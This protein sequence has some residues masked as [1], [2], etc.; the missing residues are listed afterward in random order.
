MLTGVGEDRSFDDGTIRRVGRPG[1]VPVS[2]AQRRMLFI[3][4][5]QPGHPVYNLPMMQQITGP[6]DR[7]VLES[8]F[9][10]VIARH[11]ALRTNFVLVA[12][13]WSQVVAPPAPAALSYRDLRGVASSDVEAAIASEG[14]RP[15]ELGTGL[16][17]RA[18]LLRT[19]DEDHLFLLTV[20]HLVADG[21]SMVRFAEELGASYTA[22][23]TGSVPVLPELAV[24]YGDVALWERERLASGALDE[25]LAY[26]RG[27]L[28]GGVPV[29]EM[30]TD[31]PRP[32]TFSYA[33]ESAPVGFDADLSERVR[34]RARD[35]GVTP[36]M[37]LLA[38]YTATLARWS[39]AE[40]VM[41]GTASAN[42]RLETANV[43]GLFVSTLPM[44][45]AVDGARSFAELLE[46]VK[47]ET[48]AT[49]AD[50]EVS[51]DQ[52]VRAVN[53]RARSEPVDRCSRRCSSC[54]NDG[55]TEDR[56]PCAAVPS[57]ESVPV[58][59]HLA[60]MSTCTWSL[61]SRARTASGGGSILRRR[62]S[63]G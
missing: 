40:E 51:F 42:R 14:R 54:N 63:T 22:A 47:G 61:W 26:W 30:P 37:F 62:C 19:G 4:S 29:L 58:A 27:R 35:A 57:S 50:Q 21:T 10:T 55:G 18:A 23:L 24:Q 56:I 28:S 11:E 45:I 44:R 6:L 12:G 2:A 1:P 59:V 15:F 36:F 13:E 9:S 3:E 46:V 7:D 52:I 25:Q 48:L 43:I 39:R 20:H 60:W 33:S 8:A 41:V 49:L 53:P 17:I 38:S 5:F 34:A 32:A 16:K 31:R